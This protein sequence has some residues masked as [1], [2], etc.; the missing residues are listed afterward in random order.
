MPTSNQLDQVEKSQGKYAFFMESASIEYLKERRCN[1]SQ[2]IHFIILNVS[3]FQ[4][5]FWL[6]DTLGAI[7][8]MVTIYNIGRWQNVV[9]EL[10]CQNV[11]N[12]VD[13]LVGS[14]LL[15]EYF[16]ISLLFSHLRLLLLFDG[17]LAGSLIAKVTGSQW[18]TAPHT[19]HC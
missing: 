16:F 3:F 12:V 5:K 17:R 7:S 15:L 19:S 9:P 8:T 11:R 1:L 4:I 13:P 6:H 2:V 14:I 10:V 18:S